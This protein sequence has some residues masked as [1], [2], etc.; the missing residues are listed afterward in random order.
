M[1]RTLPSKA[2]RRFLDLVKVEGNAEIVREELEAIS[3][4]TP[5]E[6]DDQPCPFTTFLLGMTFDTSLEEEPCFTV[7]F[8]GDF[9]G[10]EVSVDREPWDLDNNEGITVF[11][12][13]DP[14]E[15]AYCH[16][17]ADM[18]TAPVSAEH[19]TKYNGRSDELNED[20]AAYFEHAKL[21]ERSALAE[22]WPDEYGLDEADVPSGATEEDT[23][24]VATIPALADLALKPAVQQ[25]IENADFEVLERFAGIPE[26][27]SSMLNALRARH[28]SSYSPTTLAFIAKLVEFNSTNIDLSGLTIPSDE[29]LKILSAIRISAP[30]LYLN[31]SHNQHVSVDTV[32]KLLKARPTI[33]RLVLYGTS[34][35]DED[36][37]SLLNDEPALFYSVDEL[38]H[39]FMFSRKHPHSKHRAAFSIILSSDA[40][41]P[42]QA[43]FASTPLLNPTV[44]LQSLV[45]LFRAWCF[46]LETDNPDIQFNPGIQ[47]TTAL[48]VLSGGIRKDGQRWGERPVICMPISS[49]QTPYEGWSFVAAFS[50]WG[51]FY[52]SPLY[53]FIRPKRRL[54]LDESGT[55]KQCT[56]PEYDIFDLRDFVT[57][58]KAEGYPEPPASLVDEAEGQLERV[59]EL[60]SKMIS[61]HPRN[62]C[63]SGTM[64]GLKLF[65][66][67]PQL[68][69][70]F[71]ESVRRYH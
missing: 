31:I 61:E 5:L 43:S 32:R 8:G 51:P 63:G 66:E 44:I 67:D 62:Y 23:H 18:T 49:M 9:H 27:A 34:I 21:I 71:F 16:G 46:V 1:A 55:R 14:K 54:E 24:A 36:L 6:S 59:K 26:K 50:T 19:Y 12:V 56:L 70:E 35:D 47:Q 45:D 13:T 65:S 10:S 20:L 37:E 60:V 33:H 30:I 38:M 41:T 39:P 7:H 52:V 22:T 57:E 4:G 17:L 29:L 40:L 28:D 11:D 58:L 68:L 53:G 42:P 15:P 2:A 25:A 48:A 64:K 69:S 3:R